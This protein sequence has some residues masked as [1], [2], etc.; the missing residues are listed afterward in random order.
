MFRDTDV[1]FVHW[2]LM[3]DSGNLFYENVPVMRRFQQK[4]DITSQQI[5]DG[6]GNCTIKAIVRANKGNTISYDY[7]H[8]PVIRDKNGS[9]ES[10]KRCDN[11]GKDI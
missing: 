8:D 11:S 10:I 7:A 5:K 2:Q 6:G 9:E 1:V 3:S 4:L